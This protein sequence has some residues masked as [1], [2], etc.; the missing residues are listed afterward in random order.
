MNHGFPHSHFRHSK[1]TSFTHEAIEVIFEFPPHVT[2]LRIYAKTHPLTARLYASDQP[3]T[4]T[5]H[6]SIVRTITM[7]P[8]VFVAFFRTIPF[9]H[10]ALYVEHNDEFELFEVSGSVGRFQYNTR[11]CSDPGET[12]RYIEQVELGTT[13]SR[14]LGKLRELAA[15][16]PISKDPKWHCQFWVLSLIQHLEEEGIINVPGESA[17]KLKDDHDQYSDSE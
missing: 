9:N 14:M 1:S 3:R 2:A 4:D 5:I 7:P 15:S 16:E 8:R 11:K 6:Y 17:Q 13:Q 10:W 12:R